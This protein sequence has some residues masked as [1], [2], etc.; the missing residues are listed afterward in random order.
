MAFWRSKKSDDDDPSQRPS[1]EGDAANN[2]DSAGDRE[3]AGLMGKMRG[4][5]SKTR[6]ALNTDIRDLFKKEGRLVDDEFLDELFARL[7]RTDMGVES[8]ELIRDDV[9]KRLR[10]RVVHLDEVLDTISQQTQ[11][12]L[13]QESTELQMAEE[14]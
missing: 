13:Q 6:Q 8:A 7:I 12:M 10:A 9:A 2:G 5:L 14:G 4:A 11:S 3:P 1:S